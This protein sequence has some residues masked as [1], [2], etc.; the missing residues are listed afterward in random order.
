MP[1]RYLD[2]P[3][4]TGQL[5][6]HLPT[7]LGFDNLEVRTVTN[8]KQITG[9]GRWILPNDP[10]LLAGI[11]PELK[12]PQIKGNYIVVTTDNQKSAVDVT[13]FS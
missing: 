13:P 7:V 8:R 9:A 6:W 2:R 10:R 1:V 5:L 4:A 11:F 3:A 12:D